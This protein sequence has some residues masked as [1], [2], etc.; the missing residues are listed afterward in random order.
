MTWAKVTH[1]TLGGEAYVLLRDDGAA[2]VFTRRRREIAPLHQLGQLEGRGDWIP[3]DGDAE[4]ILGEAEATEAQD[5][6][7]PEL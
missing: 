3:F 4:A 1:Q 6:K 5:T 7:S 2:F